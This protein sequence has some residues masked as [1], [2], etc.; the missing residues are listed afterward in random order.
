M[1][2]GPML[3]LGRPT[4]AGGCGAAAAVGRGAAGPRIG[5]FS[6]GVGFNS[7]TVFSY[8]RKADALFRVTQYKVFLGLTRA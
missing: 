2:T 8:S 7:V 3:M 1:S 6:Q 5:H 4:A